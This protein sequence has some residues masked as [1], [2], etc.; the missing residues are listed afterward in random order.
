MKTIQEIR[1]TN[2]SPAEIHDEIVHR[3]NI[4]QTLVGELYPSILQDEI[5][6]LQQIHVH[7]YYTEKDFTQEEIERHNV[8]AMMVINEHRLV[9]KRCGYE[10]V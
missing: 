3:R 8:L 5:L 6:E 9:C 1:A 7:E 2:L 4:I 10:P